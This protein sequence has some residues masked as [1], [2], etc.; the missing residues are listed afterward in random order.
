MK[1]A[2]TSFAREFASHGYIV[3]TYDSVGGTC[4]YTE[5]LLKGNQLEPIYFDRSVP[6]FKRFK[7]ND[8]QLRALDHVIKKTKMREEEARK[9]IDFVSR[10][11]LLQDVFKMDPGAEMRLDKLIMSGH[12]HG[13]AAALRISSSDD[14]VKCCVA[15]DPWLVP[16]K[17]DIED[18][19]FDT[20]T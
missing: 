17:N 13:G 20:Y 1:E 16:L 5:R 7:S 12:C 19:S 15:F 10:P 3:F 11:G 4:G 9:V 8:H 14:R 6:F 2:H 18:G